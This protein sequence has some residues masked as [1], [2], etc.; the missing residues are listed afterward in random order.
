ML[1][2]CLD[3]RAGGAVARVGEDLERLERCNIDVAEQV[4]DVGGLVR[5]VLDGAGLRRG[6][7]EIAG[8]DAVADGVQARVATD[9]FGRLAH[10]LHAVVALGIVAGGDHDAAAGLLVAGGEVDFL[11]AAQADVDDVG[12]AFGDAADERLRKR[13]AFETHVAADDD[14]LGAQFGDER[15]ADA[16]G[17]VFVQ[18][19]GHAATDVVGLEGSDGHGGVVAHGPGCDRCQSAARP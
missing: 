18:L 14:G 1:G 17:D 11:G 15:A 12:A 2:Q 7:A 9:G 8:G 13:G 5:L 16:V 6:R 10:Q 4:L 19:I 3:D